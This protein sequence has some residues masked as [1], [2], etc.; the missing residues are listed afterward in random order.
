MRGHFDP[1][2]DKKEKALKER[3]EWRKTQPKLYGPTPQGSVRGGLG[4]RKPRP[5]TLAKTSLIEKLEE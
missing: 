4:H 3:A 5:I 2:Q 1:Y